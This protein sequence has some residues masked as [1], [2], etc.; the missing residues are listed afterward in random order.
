[1]P[2]PTVFNVGQRPVK[3]A[4]VV[5]VASAVMITSQPASAQ[6][7]GGL[8][9]GLAIGIGAGILLNELGK[10]AGAKAAPAPSAPSGT[11]RRERSSDDQSTAEAAKPRSAE[12]R[13]ADARNYAAQQAELA[14]IR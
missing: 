7:R 10:A 6:R 13:A 8:G 9:T 2:L 4:L 11:R 14:E 3:L 12:E 1:M 5:A